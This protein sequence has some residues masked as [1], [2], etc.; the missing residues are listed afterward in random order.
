MSVPPPAPAA[1]SRLP[2]GVD[3]GAV[4]VQCLHDREIR[5]TKRL[6]NRLDEAETKRQF[7]LADLVPGWFF[8]V[9][10]ISNGGYKAG[11]ADLWGRKVSRS[12][13]DLDVLLAECAKDAERIIA[14]L[15]ERG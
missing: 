6:V 8:R 3:P 10:E 2:V 5:V 15:N 7:P 9:N 14:Q 12:G 1:V 11:G 4:G 13:S